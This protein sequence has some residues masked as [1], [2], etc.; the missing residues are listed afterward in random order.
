MFVLNV[1]KRLGPDV[2]AVNSE[3]DG[4]EQNRQQRQR[5][6]GRAQN[7]ANDRAPAPAG[8]MADHENR[9]GAE[10][11]A[12]PAHEAKQ[13]GA[14]KL[15]G[16]EEGQHNGNHGEDAADDERALRDFLNYTGRRQIEM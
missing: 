7:A 13:V 1:A 3:N 15:V 6:H 10:R 16:T 4:D 5:A 11:D 12:Q 8:K 14:I 9:H 2:K